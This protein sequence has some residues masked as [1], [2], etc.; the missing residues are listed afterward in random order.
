MHSPCV[1]RCGLNEDDYCMGCLRHINEIV[2]WSSLGETQQ[3][4]IWD[5]LPQRKQI[6]EGQTNN[7]ALTRAKWLD[8]E[9]KQGS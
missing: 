2:A 3:Q 7:Q 1:A 6:F 9:A 8:A 5:K 4:T